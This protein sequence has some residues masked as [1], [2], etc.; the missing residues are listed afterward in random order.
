[1]SYKERILVTGCAGFIGMSLCKKL[2]DE[3]YL[4][5]G[6][7]NMDDYYD[8]KLKE[9]RLKELSS[10]NN[11]K[12]KKNDIV[13]LSKLEK[14][15]KQ[16]KPDKVVNLAAQAGVRYSL[17]NPH[18]Y[19]SSNIVGF[20]NILECCRHNK[21]NGLIYASS[22]SVYGGNKTIPFSIKHNV[23]KP[24]SIYA[25]TKKSN[26]LM[27]HSYSHLYKLHTTGLRFFTV[28]GPWGRPDMAIYIFTEKIIK[29]KKISVFN[30]GNMKR[31][32][33]YIDDIIDGV[34]A[35]IEKNYL[36]EIFNFGNNNPV[37][38]IDMIRIIEN[39]LNRS[40][41]IDLKKMQL[42]DVE[43]TFADIEYTKQKLAFNP[44]INLEKG[45]LEFINWFK[46]YNKIPPF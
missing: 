36:C 20:L 2:L 39:I 22:S 12:F 19:V 13:H 42:G 18:K 46:T 45:V 24:V 14:I 43:K 25:A 31:D 33:T 8:V 10:Y 6:L 41:K 26:E 15:F 16:F 28:Y 30:H 34:M 44:S 3:G 9:A 5:F 37:G 17:K 38:L 21:T 40:A 23:D 7:D 32:F 27:A 29:N 11:F 35:S 1:M 4:V